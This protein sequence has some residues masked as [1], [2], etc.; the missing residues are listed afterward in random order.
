MSASR[1]VLHFCGEYIDGRIF[2][3]GGGKADILSVHQDLGSILG[4]GVKGQD[5]SL[6][7]ALFEGDNQRI[8]KV[9]GIIQGLS[10]AHFNVAKALQF[11]GHLR[12]IGFQGIFFH[13][14]PFIAE[15]NKAVAIR[16]VFPIIGSVFFGCRSF[17]G[18]FGLFF[19]I[20]NNRSFSR[21]FCGYIFPNLGRSFSRRLSSRYLCGILRLY[22][23]R[24]LSGNLVYGFRR[25]FSGSFGR[26]FCR[27][28]G[29]N[30]RGSLG[31]FFRRCRNRSLCGSFS[32]NLRRNFSR[33]LS[34]DFRGN[35]S[36]CCVLDLVAFSQCHCQT[37]KQ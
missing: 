31:R 33:N 10:D 4:S 32:G 25:D 29:S 34:R 30:F 1:G 5:N 7:V 8:A 35:L 12:S 24:S 14:A 11:I 21:S 23:S 26:Y 6:G 20:R 18:N 22:F 2:I 28:F 15:L 19:R 13:V 9:N 16:I 3:L 17:S 37:G 27:S 36:R